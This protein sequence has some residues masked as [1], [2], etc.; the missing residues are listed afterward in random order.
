MCLF[1]RDSGSKNTYKK[2]NEGEFS[3]NMKANSKHDV[4]M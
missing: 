1:S 2:Y 3:Y 4:P